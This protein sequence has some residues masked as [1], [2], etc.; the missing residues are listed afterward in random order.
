MQ[1]KKNKSKIFKILT[2]VFLFIASIVAMVFGSVNI[3]NNNSQKGLFGNSYFIS[4]EVDLNNNKTRATNEES[5]QSDATAFSEWLISQNINNTNVEYELNT[6]NKGFIYTNILNVPLISYRDEEVEQNPEWVSLDTI[7]TSRIDIYQIN[8][9]KESNGN[10]NDYNN[11]GNPSFASGTR[12]SKILGQENLNIDSARLDTREEN[13]NFGIQVNLDTQIDID[14]FNEQKLSTPESGKELKWIVI[15]DKEILIQKLNYAK[16]L[17]LKKSQ[18]NADEKVIFD[19]DTLPEEYKTWAEAAGTLATDPIRENNLLYYYDLSSNNTGTN[20]PNANSNLKAIVDKFILGTI[21]YS[22]YNNWFPDSKVIN[23][24]G[25]SSGGDT[26]T[27]TGA[28]TRASSDGT[29]A[30][31]RLSFQLENANE[32]NQKFF[33][34]RLTKM[35]F[36]NPIVSLNTSWTADQTNLND[37]K[38]LGKSWI[39]QPYLSNNLS[40]MKAYEA[41]LLAIGIVL[42]IIAIVVSVL[43]RVPGIFGAMSVV[44]AAVLS[45]S[46]FVVLNINFSIPAILGILISILASLFSVFV[47]ME[48]MRKNAKE[49]VSVFDSIGQVIKRSLFTVL[50]VNMV[51]L[52]FGLCLVF[53][54][55]SELIDF[56]LSLIVVA[57][58]TLVC[59]YLLFIFP[60]YIIHGFNNLWNFKYF[61]ILTRKRYDHSTDVYNDSK[62]TK[63][64]EKN[65]RRIG[66]PLLVVAC[67]IIII[68]FVL[69]FT[70][71]VQNSA[72]YNNGTVIYVTVAQDKIK[73]ILDALGKNWK[74]EWYN[75]GVL[76][77]SAIGNY[78]YDSINSIISQVVNGMNGSTDLS[79]TT[80]TPTLNIS[81]AKSAMDSALIAMALLSIYYLFRL[82]V[83]TI[84]PLFIANVLGLLLPL[85]LVYILWIPIDSFYVYSMLF[86]SI[87]STI[88]NTVFI[89]VTKTRFNKKTIFGHDEIMK[90]II[91][92]MN[93]LKNLYLLQSLSVVLICAFMAAL[94]STS[95][96]LMFAYIVIGSLISLWFGHYLVGSIYFVVIMIRQKYVRNFAQSIDKKINQVGYDKVDEQLIENINKFN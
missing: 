18:P 30:V 84:I 8:G 55:Q 72:A 80:T 91:G 6:S 12:Y 94:G 75:N 43:Y 22:N 25:N 59:S 70:I 66:I 78:S 11:G 2:I 10:T 42:L 93:N 85:T 9:T 82:S 54:G 41:S 92:N 71:G 74:F 77:A 29:P 87:F 40:G 67:V 39:N 90:F 13:N 73:P 86:V 23:E 62:Y 32:Q 81:I 68:G 31:A 34:N 83:F 14:G 21:T 46:L 58:V 7:K 47:I 19:W 44:S 35:T 53:F 51:V 15:Q 79:V 36:V 88:T 3:G 89:S 48:R 37:F 45:A 65:K 1:F 28:V 49:K 20:V 95:T 5:L 4:F 16:F 61:L 60:L 69:A 56:G 33:L 96:Q 27:K 76:S 63:F 50:D 52:V 24:S 17:Y 57:L 26:N 64:L 38:T